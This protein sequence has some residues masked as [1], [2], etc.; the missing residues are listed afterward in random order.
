MSPDGSGARVIVRDQGTSA[1]AWS[2][3]GRLAY[4]SGNGSVVRVLGARKEQASF[5]VPG[6]AD[7]LAWSPKGKRLLVSARTGVF[8]SELYAVDAR[9]GRFT[10]LTTYMGSIQGMS[11][12]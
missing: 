9:S 2:T 10:Q 8:P 7:A 11:W 1:L 6:T 3:A 12:R 4:L 5:R